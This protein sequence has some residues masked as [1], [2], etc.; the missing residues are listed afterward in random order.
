MYFELAAKQDEG[1][2]ITLE[3]KAWGNALH[4]EHFEAL[5]LDQLDR[6]R[7]NILASRCQHHENMPSRIDEEL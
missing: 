4:R 3:M 1:Y 5:L 2:P 6:L 7:W